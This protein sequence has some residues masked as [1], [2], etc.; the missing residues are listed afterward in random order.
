MKK[1]V[2]ILLIL[3]IA[4]AFSISSVAAVD[5]ETQDFD[6][7]FSVDVIKGCDFDRTDLDGVITFMDIDKGVC[8]LYMDDPVIEKNMDDVFY[9]SFK[10]SSGFDDAGTDGDIRIFYDGSQYATLVTDDGIAIG[11]MHKDKDTVV[12][13]TKTIELAD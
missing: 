13:M 3:A 7:K 1:Y 4:C 6:N 11:V 2:P 5:L 9:D 10:S 12:E 8:V